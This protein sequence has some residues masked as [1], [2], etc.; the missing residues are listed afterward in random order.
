MPVGSWACGGVGGAGA[1]NA[2]VGVGACNAVSVGAYVATTC[3]CD[4]E[5]PPVD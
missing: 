3:G 5:G 4:V 2:V 1:G